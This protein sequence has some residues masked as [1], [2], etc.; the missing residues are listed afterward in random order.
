MVR[1]FSFDHSDHDRQL[2]SSRPGARRIEQKH[3]VD[4]LVA[5]LM[6][7]SEHDDVSVLLEELRSINVRQENSLAA[8]GHANDVVT[9]G[10]VVVAADEGD[11]RDLTERF[12]DVLAAD[13]AGVQDRIDALQRSQSFGTN[14]TVRIGDDSDARLSPRSTL[15]WPRSSLCIDL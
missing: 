1:A 15:S 10:I 4:N 11:R 8:D 13:V 6:T 12:D 2:E 3:A 9:I 14:Q 5:R 7:V